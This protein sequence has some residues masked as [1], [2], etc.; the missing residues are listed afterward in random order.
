MIPAGIVHRM[1]LQGILLDRHSRISLRRQLVGHLEARILGGQIAPGRRLPSV[2]RAQE[3]LGLHR[4]TV[5][6][7]YRDLVRAGLVRTRPGSGVYVRR[8]SVETGRGL[9]Q[10]VVRG[11]NQIDLVCPDRDLAPVLR[12]ELERRIPARVWI[13]PAGAGEGTTIRLSPPP[14]FIRSVRLLPRPSVVAVISASQLVHRLA[15]VAVLIHGGERIGYLPVNSAKDSDID[16]VKRVA[17]VV[18][19]DCAELDRSHR[20]HPDGT[21]P[22]PIISGLSLASVT[23]ALRRLEAS[24]PAGRRSANVAERY[25]RNGVEE[26]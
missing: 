14:G 5:A 22:L 26:P 12:A 17:R 6:A 20:S 25:L 7:A 16:R 11:R 3:Y 2:R 10:A 9:P 19:A 18:F 15:S 23:M 24:S 13:V 4:N 1:M 21:L 8:E